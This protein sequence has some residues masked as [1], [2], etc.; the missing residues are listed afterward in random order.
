MCHA[1]S[2]DSPFFCRWPCIAHP[3][4]AALQIPVA[5]PE[6]R[7]YKRLLSHWRG[8]LDLLQPLLIHAEGNVGEGSGMRQ[9]IFDVSH[10]TATSDDGELAFMPMIEY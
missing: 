4:K 7:G 9:G 5:L 6:E 10:N 1:E 3:K 2:D 8:V